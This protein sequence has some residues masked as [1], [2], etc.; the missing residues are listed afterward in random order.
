MLDLLLLP[1]TKL[2]EVLPA[3]YVPM[4]LPVALLA[5]WWFELHQRRR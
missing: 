5:Q 1:L 3:I 2:F 4:E